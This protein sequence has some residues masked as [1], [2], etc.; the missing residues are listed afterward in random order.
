L[1]GLHGRS[2]IERALGNSVVIGLHVVAQCGLDV[3]ADRILTTGGADDFLDYL[4][5]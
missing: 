3:G 2:V 4:E 5:G 1:K